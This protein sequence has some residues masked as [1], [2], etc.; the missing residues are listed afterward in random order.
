MLPRIAQALALAA[1]LL[2]LPS[3]FPESAA[4]APASCDLRSCPALLAVDHNGIYRITGSYLRQHG[5]DWSHVS[6]N[7]LSLQLEGQPIPRAVSTSGSL[8]DSSYLEFYAPSFHTRYSTRAVYTLS[9]DRSRALPAAPMPAA[10]GSGP[11]LAT[12]F[13]HS[14]ESRRTIYDPAAP[15]EGWFY[16][17]LATTGD[18]VDTSATIHL[19]GLVTTGNAG[20]NVAARGVTDLAG[21]GPQHHLQVIV[22]GHQV[23][24]STFSGTAEQAVTA[25]FPAAWLDGQRT[26]VQFVLPGDVRNQ[27]NTD[28]VEIRT[29]DVTYPRTFLA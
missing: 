26:S 3:L 2:R 5:F 8:G 16:A 27:Y 28:I 1:L 12:F 21:T 25:T 6:G 22:D 13:A 29:F 24:D 23:A 9:V 10:P 19:P 14:V 17:Q 15:G 18:R 20:I 11:A 4:A 7:E